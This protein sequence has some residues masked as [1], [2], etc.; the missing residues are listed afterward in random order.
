MALDQRVMV[1]PPC[2]GV[3]GLQ[4]GCQGE[5]C[6]PG[7][8]QRAPQVPH[9]EL[10]KEPWQTMNVEGRP[11]SHLPFFSQKSQ[12]QC[13]PRQVMS[14]VFFP[15]HRTG[16]LKPGG[17][18]P[19]GPARPPL[20][21]LRGREGGPAGQLAVRSGGLGSVCPLGLAPRPTRRP[22]AAD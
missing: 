17:V 15:A 10:R 14:F 2:A 1:A 16:H 9:P 11:P 3:R 5:V 4:P 8:R 12:T 19:P 22:L 13:V 21:P 18:P 6:W 7:I 20:F